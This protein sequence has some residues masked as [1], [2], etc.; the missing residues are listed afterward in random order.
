MKNDASAIFI[1]AAVFYVAQTL[2]VTL[3]FGKAVIVII[4][5]TA[6]VTALPNVPSASVVVVITILSS[7]GLDPGGVSLLYAVEWLN[8]RLRSGSIVFSH[9]SCTA[10]VY[11]VCEKDLKEG[12]KGDE[13]FENEEKTHVTAF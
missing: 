12:R 5:T 10:F 4:L 1:V 9:I 7:I 2:N 13:V 8:D 3:D 6:Y 11:H